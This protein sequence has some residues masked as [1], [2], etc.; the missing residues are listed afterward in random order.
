MSLTLTFADPRTAADLHTFVARARQVDDGGIRLAVTGSVLAATVCVLRPPGFG[1]SGP[2]VLGLRTMALADDAA[3]GLDVTVPLGA[4]ADR[5]ARTAE[6]ADDAARRRLPVPPTTLTEPWAGIAAP[7]RGWE[8]L[9]AVSTAA[10]RG[11]A[12]HG[13]ELVRDALPQDAGSA[14]LHTVRR[15]VL[16]RSLLDSSAAGSFDAVAD[17]VPVAAAYAAELLG[18]L[19]V[20]PRSAD[21]ATSDDAD[22]VVLAQ[23]RWLRLSTAR[24][25]VLVKH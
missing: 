9:G 24:G 5:L 10:L 16:A 14:V 15:A 7:R 4:V 13:I 22:A 11:A 2:T 8:R 12:R 23:G 25:H 6:N 20:A 18:F 19:P 21:A 17:R 1:E 3:D